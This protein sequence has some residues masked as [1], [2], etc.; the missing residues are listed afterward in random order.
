MPKTKITLGGGEALL[1]AAFLFATTNVL[2]REMSHM[3]GDQ[4]QVAARFA[5]VWIIL[6]G[7]AY[8][9]K[10]K[11]SIPRSKLPLA[12]GYSV[13]A[14]L[15]IL[16]FTVSLQLTTIANTLFMS[17]AAELVIAFVLG[18]ILLREKLN[19]LK[20]AA[21]GLSLTGLALYADSLLSGSAG[22]LFGLLGGAMTAFCNLIAKKL[23]GVDLTA[24]LRLQFG[25]GALLMITLTL[26]LSPHDIVRTVSMEGIG[27]TLAFALVLIA[28]TRFVLYG[29]QHFDVNIASVLLSTQLVIGALLGYFF[30]QEVP[31]QLELI[32]GLL[33][34]CAAILGSIGYKRSTREIDVHP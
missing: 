30:Y 1:A 14:S 9:K 20:L 23:K 31:T 22:I 29:F 13:L 26:I 24:I 32:S 27:V 28:A 25:V 8:F 2:V 17:N 18:T 6:M 21:I 15:A 16:A 10:S 34:A 5:L 12:I 4:A 7:F 3:W 19:G 33:I 11:T